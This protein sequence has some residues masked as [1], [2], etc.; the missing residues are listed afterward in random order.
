[1]LRKARRETSYPVLD[2]VVDEE[3]GERGGWEM[4]F[5]RLSKAR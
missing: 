5:Y 2:A 3:D 1:M 4:D